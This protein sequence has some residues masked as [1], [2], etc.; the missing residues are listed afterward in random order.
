MKGRLWSK[1]NKSKHISILPYTGFFLLI[2]ESHDLWSVIF[3]PSPVLHPYFL[4]P[5]LQ[6]SFAL[7][8]SVVTFGGN[9]SVCWIVEG[10]STRWRKS[11]RNAF[12]LQSFITEMLC[13]HGWW[14]GKCGA[15]DCLVISSVFVGTGEEPSAH[16]Q[17]HPTEADFN[18]AKW[19]LIR[20]LLPFNLVS[21]LWQVLN[22][23]FLL[24]SN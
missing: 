15:V 20:I 11:I 9:V 2:L 24:S 12:S 3:P 21:P 6:A 8:F 18:S 7:Y 4:F 16:S 23:N 13:G 5:S 22:Q 1:V 17:N 10:D 19:G 14:V